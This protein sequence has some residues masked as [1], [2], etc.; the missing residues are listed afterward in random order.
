V[1]SGPHKRLDAC[2]FDPPLDLDRVETHEPSDLQVRDPAF[3]D[4]PPD[5]ANG[6]TKTG[7]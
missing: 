1:Y 7:G 2:G 5:E 3:V 4:Q 6:H